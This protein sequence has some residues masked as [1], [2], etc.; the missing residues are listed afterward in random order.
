MGG[1]L[2]QPGVEIEHVAG[3]GLTTGRAAQQ[4]AQRAV[5]YGVLGEVVVDDE[6][7]PPLV[8]EVLAQ[9]AAGVG[10]D[11]LQ[12]G[13]VACGG[14][15]HDG[16]VEGA[17]LVQRLHD[18]GD[19]ACL[20]ADGDVDAYDVLAAL[21]EDGVERY[22][23]LAGLAVADDELA[24]TAAYG[25]HGVYG[26]QARL[27]GAVDRLAVDYLGSAGLYGAVAV[28]IYFALA[29]Y[30]R[31]QGVY[32]ASQEGVADGYARGLAAA[33]HPAA[34]G[35][36]LG[37]AEEDAAEL[38]LTQLLHHA[39]DPAGEE[40]YLA[41]GGVLEPGHG[42]DAVAHR[43]HLAQ[44]LGRGL[45]R[46]VVHGLTDEGDDVAGGGVE[47]LHL[48]AEAAQAALYAP[49]VHVRA[50]LKHKAAGEGGV[51]LP[52]EGEVVPVGS[53]QKVQEPISLRLGRL[54]RTAEDGGV[55]TRRV[56]RCPSSRRGS[57]TARRG[58]RPAGARAFPPP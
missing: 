27:D 35:Y 9:G 48:L 24:L 39:L 17:E 13:G 47:P 15:D 58:R 18:L 56:H 2:Q 49:V 34:L 5:G 44:L 16:V 20:L 55:L 10:G 54:C 41:V 7:V 43:E 4:Q 3:V 28:G 11:V 19:G 25:E 38:V 1:A 37:A 21:V 31:A 50:G 6:H 22:G 12:R 57:G 46:P 53:A 32:D 26:Q 51:L 8:H 40:Q 52:L 30:G 14:A 45:R 36:G 29:V 42:G 33:A 23:R